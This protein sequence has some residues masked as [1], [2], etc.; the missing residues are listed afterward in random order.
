MLLIKLN[1]FYSFFNFFYFSSENLEKI[2]FYKKARLTFLIYLSKHDLII[3]ENDLSLFDNLDDS[4]KIL[5]IKLIADLDGPAYSIIVC[6]INFF[7]Y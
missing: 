4:C 7:I 3:M 1:K 6:L 5:L 2:L